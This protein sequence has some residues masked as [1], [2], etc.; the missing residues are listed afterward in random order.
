MKLC[1][2]PAAAVALLALSACQ[3]KAEEVT[4]TAP[5]PMASQLANRAPVELPPM[6]T[7]DVTFRCKDQSLV[8]VD[9]FQ[10]DKQLLVKTTKEGTPVK[11]TAEKAGDPYKADG[12][13]ATGT[14]KSITLTVPGKDAQVCKV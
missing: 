14:P 8:Y 5:D 3:N 12:Y 10:G 2:L 7:A 13:V 6:M 9:F 4:S 11:L 1:I